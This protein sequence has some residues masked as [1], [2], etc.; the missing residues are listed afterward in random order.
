MEKR[1][2]GRHMTDFRMCDRHGWQS[3]G[4]WP[5]YAVIQYARARAS[6]SFW[7]RSIEFGVA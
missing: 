5:A 7:A 3:A 4:H 2:E 6:D 1:G